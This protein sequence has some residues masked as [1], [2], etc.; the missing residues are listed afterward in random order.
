MYAVSDILLDISLDV[1]QNILQD[2]RVTR[3]PFCKNSQL[4]TNS[5]A[6]LSASW[7]CVLY[8]GTCLNR[9]KKNGKQV[10]EDW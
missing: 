1:L 7:L 4:T 5:H 6:M 3:T 9:Y 10:C 8:L 2:D